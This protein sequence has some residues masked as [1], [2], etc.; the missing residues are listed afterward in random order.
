M[1]KMH[2]P[3]LRVIWGVRHSEGISMYDTPVLWLD[4]DGVAHFVDPSCGEIIDTTDVDAHRY[5]S[6]SASYSIGRRADASDLANSYRNAYEQV[7][8]DLLW[9]EEGS[10]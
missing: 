1:T 8:A 7:K 6:D 2:V 4:P 3:G 9:S 5:Y 10:A